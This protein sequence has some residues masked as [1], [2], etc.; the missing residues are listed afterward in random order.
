M[1]LHHQKRQNTHQR[2]TR[3]LKGKRIDQTFGFL[4]FRETLS[5]GAHRCQCCGGCRTSVYE[6]SGVFYR[7]PH[8][9]FDSD[10]QDNNGGMRRLR[11]RLLTGEQRPSNLICVTLLGLARRINSWRLGRQGGGWGS[12][13]TV[14]VRT[15][16]GSKR[17]TGQQPFDLCS[18]SARNQVRLRRE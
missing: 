11:R 8:S 14:Q 6:I 17:V 15:E 10:L 5:W 4:F 3:K 16:R 1:D 9:G 2:Q 18:R 12:W 13:A 7:L